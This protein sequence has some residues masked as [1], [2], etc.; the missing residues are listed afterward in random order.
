VT[1]F[2]GR[3]HLDWACLATRI[4]CGDWGA[5]SHSRGPEDTGKEKVKGKLTHLVIKENQPPLRS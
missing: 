3:L 5:C 2:K 4:R 1:L